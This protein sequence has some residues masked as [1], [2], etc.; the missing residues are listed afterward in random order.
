M[1]ETKF[2]VGDRVKRVEEEW[3]GMKIGD[4]DTVVCPE[5]G[6]AYTLKRYGKGHANYNLERVAKVKSVKPPSP[7]KFILQ[8][9]L[10]TDPFEL[11]ATEKELRKR[12]AE[13]AERSDLKR[14][15]IKVYDIKKV[16]TVTLGT[17]ITI[18]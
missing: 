3:G 16:R 15:S 4:E 12:I 10:D 18:K 1:A 13:L 2:K 17:K 11:F 7:P 9:E 14:D 5:P 6:G 8:Y